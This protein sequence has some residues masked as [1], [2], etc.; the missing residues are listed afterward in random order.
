MSTSATHTIYERLRSDLLTGRRRPDERLKINEL[1]LAFQVSIGAVREA[2]SRLTSEGLVI[3]EPQ[4][5]FRVAPVS[6]ADLRDL[7]M[8]RT[9]IEVRCLRRAIACGD[10][11]WEAAIIASHHR[12]VRTELHP[13]DGRPGFSDGWLAAHADFH[14]MLTSACDS[15]WSLKLRE[16]LFTQ[17]E[18]YRDLAL[19]ADKGER[20][21][22]REHREL[23]EAVLARDVD[24]AITRITAHLALTTK[25]IETA[26][27][28]QPA[29][30]SGHR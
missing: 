3:A 26:F 7:T 23:M 16:M 12:L 10:A 24:L 30:D 11:A 1:G 9:E 5:G 27:H 2:L 28:R 4:R 18:R 8:V 25:S 29:N 6:L 14:R 20:D 19:I 13:K 21:V 15:P 17:S 22:Q